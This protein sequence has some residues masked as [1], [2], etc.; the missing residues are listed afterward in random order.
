[1]SRTTRMRVLNLTLHH[2]LTHGQGVMAEAATLDGRAARQAIEQRTLI[3]ETTRN[4][5]ASEGWTVT[6]IDGGAA[7]RYTGIEATRGTEHLLAAVG[8]DELIADQ[9]GAHDCAATV[10][11]IA[12][13]LRAIGATPT[14]T[15]DVPHDGQGGTLYAIQGGPTQAHAIA[16]TL[17]RAVAPAPGRRRAAPSVLR[18]TTG[19]R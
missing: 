4:A 16:A 19:D 1:M 14:V 8:A 18:T 2:A 12:G 7:D 5:L 13:G 9:A 11:V 17:R 3:A 10:E 15:D 6:M